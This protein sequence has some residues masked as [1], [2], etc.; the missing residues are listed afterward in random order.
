MAAVAAALPLRANAAQN[1]E[2]A[3]E[4]AALLEK[5]R[6]QGRSRP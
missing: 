1:P 4:M 2:K 3:K 6:D 5:L